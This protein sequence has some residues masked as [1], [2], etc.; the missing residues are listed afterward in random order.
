MERVAKVNF[1]SKIMSKDKFFKLFLQN[2]KKLFTYIV[3]CVPNYAD[4]ED[5]LQDVVSVMWEKFDSYED[6]TNFYAWAKQIAKY[7]VSY[8]YRSQKDIWRFDNDVLENII[9][10]NENIV[11]SH[12]SRAVA[13]QGCLSKLGSSD[14]ELIKLRFQE[15]ISARQI[16][17]ETGVSVS[18]LYKHLAKVYALLG[19]CITRTLLAWESKQ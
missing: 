10:A 6:G 13:L 16:A 8:Y 1:M 4:A 9:E 15:N 2:N 5:I 12:D 19:N 11:D 18:K 14:L 3:S 7:K 17:K